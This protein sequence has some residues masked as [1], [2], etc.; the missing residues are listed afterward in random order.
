MMEVLN[1]LTDEEGYQVALQETER[2]KETE[3]LS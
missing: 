1:V 3:D 2:Q